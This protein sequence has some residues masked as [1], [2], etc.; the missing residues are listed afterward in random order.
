MKML[1]KIIDNFRGFL[2]GE[3][4]YK[5]DVTLKNTEVNSLLLAKLHMQKIKE[6]SN[7]NSLKDVEFKVF[8]QWGEDGIIQYILS[9]IPI[10]NEIFIEIGMENYTESNTRFLLINDNWKGLIIDG[11]S[12]SIKY[13]KSD[14]IYWKHDLTAICK[15]ITRENINDLIASAGISGDIGLLSIDIDGN[16]Y[17]IW[18]AITMVSPRIVICEYN[19]VLGDDYAI[20]IPYDPHFIATQAH[21]SG[22]YFGCSLPAL[23]KLADAKGYDFI[24]S[25][26]VGV[27]AFFV[28]K[29]LS[30]PFKVVTP[31]EGYIE[32]KFRISKDKYGS[33]SY[34]SGRDRLGVIADLK[35]YDL[36][37]GATRPL[38]EVG[39]D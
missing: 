18:D 16:D 25:N 36:E 10:E 28:R 21:Y 8:S 14:P 37:L 4:S 31:Q 22:L 32:G 26:S 11:N 15:F 9:K 2:L 35:I 17:W 20:T 5:V 39:G 12:K 13:I 29:D 1:K 6:Q 38:R 3:F 27:N 30:Q 34:V 19:T 23:C 24:G 7:I 33:L